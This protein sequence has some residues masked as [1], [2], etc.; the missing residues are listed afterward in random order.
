MR[1]H[2]RNFFNYRISVL[3]LC[4][5]FGLGVLVTLAVT[6][7]RFWRLSEIKFIAIVIL[8]AAINIGSIFIIGLLTL[9]IAA[10]ICTIIELVKDRRLEKHEFKNKSL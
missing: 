5:T 8:D 1:R 2:I 9:L 4:I 7:L 6:G 10:L 3:D